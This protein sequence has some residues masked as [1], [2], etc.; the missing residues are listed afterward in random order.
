MIPDSL[1][2][3]LRTGVASDAGVK[4]EHGSEAIR[5]RCQCFIL[6]LSRPAFTYGKLDI[7]T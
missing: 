7:S 1:K 5:E 4:N 2:T 3:K 6:I